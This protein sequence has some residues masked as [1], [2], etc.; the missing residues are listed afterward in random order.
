MENLAEIKKM[1]PDDVADLLQEMEEEERQIVLSE[2]DAEQRSEVEPLLKFP[3]DCAAGLMNPR[4]AKVRDTSKVKDAT[5]E[6]RSSNS[7]ASYFIY[8]IDAKGCLRGRLSYKNLILAKE[9][10]NIENVMN[11]E[12]MG[13]P[14][15]L[16]Q[17]HVAQLFS[18]LDLPEMPVVDKQNRLLG[19]ITFDDV[20][21]VVEEEATEDLQKFAA[22]ESHKQP[23]LK[24]SFFSAIRKRGAWLLLLFLCGLT[25][26]TV[27]QYFSVALEKAVVLAAFLPL[28]I[29][30][31]GN[32][33]SQ[34]TSLIIRALALGD[35][36]LRNWWKVLV[37]EA[38]TGLVLGTLLGT[39][40]LLRI[41]LWPTKDVDPAFQ[42]LDLAGAVSLSL[43]CVV[44]AGA[45]LGSMLP[46]V[47]QK[48]RLD[49][50]TA[51]APLVS[52]LL[53]LTGL[54][55]YFTIG[56]ALLSISL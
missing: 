19:V 43:V 45:I 14:E 39:A 53:D 11:R 8:V 37:R 16:D 40:G 44:T 29:S 23:Y 38:G 17:E 30:S 20:A 1:P 46:F 26:V 32:A 4:F 7:E 49:P 48:L 42:I 34:A 13:I 47:L 28:V 6:L 51:S 50:A 10:E 41:L 21:D 55:L 24:I 35:V 5:F 18:K 36:Q 25:T 9:D 33:G 27:I 2:L 52:T 12:I 15:L 56:S 22:I 31:G 3:E 54:F